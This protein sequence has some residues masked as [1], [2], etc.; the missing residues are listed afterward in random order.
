MHSLEILHRLENCFSVELH[1][2][3][4]SMA[5]WS[6]RDSVLRDTGFTRLTCSNS[7][8]HLVFWLDWFHQECFCLKA[9]ILVLANRKS[10]QTD[11]KIVGGVD[12]KRWSA[13]RNKINSLHSEAGLPS[14]QVSQSQEMISVKANTQGQCCAEHT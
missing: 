11:C 4:N 8:W 9:C 10:M 1:A 14:F 13:F 5:V 12:W 3:T 6:V 7:Q 2:I